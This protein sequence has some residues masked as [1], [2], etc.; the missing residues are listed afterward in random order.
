M[1]VFCQ[2]SWRFGI[3]NIRRWHETIQEK[4][5]T[6]ITDRGVLVLMRRQVVFWEKGTNP[7]RKRSFLIIITTK[8]PKSLKSFILEPLWKAYKTNRTRFEMRT[9][10]V[11]RWIHPATPFCLI[12]SRLRYIRPCIQCMFNANLKQNGGRRSKQEPL[13]RLLTPHGWK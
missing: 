3:F 10:K 4:E 12:P 11:D 1:S 2:R 6:G 8:A 7:Q 5:L 9:T 13:I